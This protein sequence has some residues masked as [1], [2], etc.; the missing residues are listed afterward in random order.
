MA[1]IAINTMYPIVCL[2]VRRIIEKFPSNGCVSQNMKQNVRKNLKEFFLTFST[3][4]TS[5]FFL[6]T[7]QCYFIITIHV[8]VNNEKKMIA[9]LLIVKL[10]LFPP[11]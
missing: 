6:G 1:T 5:N 10:I 7:Q 3:F 9:W 4:D 8:Y 11:R 2:Y